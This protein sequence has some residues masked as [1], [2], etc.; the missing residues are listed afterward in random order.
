MIWTPSNFGIWSSTITSAIPALKPISTGSEMKLAMNP[1][2][3]SDASM[4]KTPTR[5][6]SVAEAPIN[7]AESPSTAIWP[8]W[9]AVNMA[10]VVVVLTLRGREVPSTA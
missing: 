3:K 5:S 10:S 2:R 6:V 9:A 7:D 8:S 1:S 4:R